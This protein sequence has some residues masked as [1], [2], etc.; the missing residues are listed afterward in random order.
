MYLFKIIII[1]L[2]VINVTNSHVPRKISGN[3]FND[4]IVGKFKDNINIK[5]TV[6]A[7]IKEF[8]NNAERSN[9]KTR[10]LRRW[11]SN[12]QFNPGSS[13]GGRRQTQTD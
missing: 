3:I 8:I 6:N 2:S 11:P 5:D 4:Y 12:N 10:G 7:T 1:I 13:K 9:N